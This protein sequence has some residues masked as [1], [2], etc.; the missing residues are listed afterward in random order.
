[1]VHRA[2]MGCVERFMAVLIEHYAGAFPLWLAPVQAAVIPVSNQRHLAY[3]ESL[4]ERL[5]A[6]GFRVEV[7]VA[8]ERMQAK[9]R[10]A[11]LEKV[12]YMLIAG[13]REMAEGSVSVRARDQGEIGSLSVGDLLT[14]MRDEISASRRANDG[15]GG[16]WN[17]RCC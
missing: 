16:V 2:L 1:M 14:R 5:R 12:P 8:N 4:G 6:E 9:I 17:T 7:D 11:Q 15:N 3:A 13:N 10:R